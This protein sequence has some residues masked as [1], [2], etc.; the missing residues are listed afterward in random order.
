MK[1]PFNCSLAAIILA[2]SLALAA[3]R[4]KEAPPAATVPAA[5]PVQAAAA[6]ATAP[7]M[8]TSDALTEEE[9]RSYVAAQKKAGEIAQARKDAADPMAE[10][11]KALGQDPARHERVARIVRQTM[12]NQVRRGMT[13]FAREAMEEQRRQTALRLERTKDPEA[14]KLVEE[15]LAA[16][17]AGLRRLDAQTAPP[18]GAEG[19]NLALLQK[20]QKELSDIRETR[21]AARPPAP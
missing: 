11:L 13:G 3:C 21:E 16:A 10:A 15:E 12:E 4:G 5:A 6:T 8:S 17:E 14:R 1:M 20:F 7:S 19:G 2:F 9:V 18:T